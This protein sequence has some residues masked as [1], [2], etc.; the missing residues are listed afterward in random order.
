MIRAMP[1]HLDTPEGWPE[2]SEGR[3]EF[4]KPPVIE[5][6]LSAQFSALTR[7]GVPHI[8]L[9][10]DVFRTDFPKFEDQSAL[11]HVIE[12]FG[13]PKR[14]SFGYKVATTPAPDRCWFVSSDGSEMI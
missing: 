12:H 6:V 14:V 7:M 10:W 3:P 11:Q 8:G 1:N 4:G 2:F 5:V 9:L 13:P